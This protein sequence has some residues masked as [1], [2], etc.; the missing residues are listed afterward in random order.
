[1]LDRPLTQFLQPEIWA[2][3]AATSLGPSAAIA[4]AAMILALLADRIPGQAGRA[5]ALLALFGAGLSL[6][7]TGHAS[8]AAP[9][10][11]TRPAVLLHTTG[12]AFWAGA[13]L[14]LRALLKSGAPEALPALR[15]FSRAIPLVLAALVLAG[16]TLAIVQLGSPRALAETPYGRILLAKLALV[17]ALL[18]LGAINRWRLTEQ[19]QAS[20]S[21]ARRQL[22]RLIA[23]ETVL[24]LAVF[25]IVA[26]WRFTPPPR[27]LAPSAPIA[28]SLAAADTMADI[29]F[30]TD[31][32]G[33]ADIVLMQGSAPLAAQ[34]VS[35]SL[36]N[37]SSGIE[38]ISYPAQ[39]TASGAWQVHDLVIPTAGQWS[40]RLDLRISD[41]QLTRLSGQVLLPA[42]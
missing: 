34:A 36:G 30:A 15:N 16:A 1:V 25:C 14:P 28:L 27:A 23:V 8:A 18:A 19:S 6:A 24:V 3:G 35:L 32:S 12:I 11:L 41:F 39:P 38:A 9:Q 2:A 4:I 42:N 33:I 20:D 10:W 26:L 22:L 29:S 21:A 17:A 40:V 7:V 37:P 13:L 5:V 31:G